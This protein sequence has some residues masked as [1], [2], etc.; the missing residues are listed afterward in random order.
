M[1]ER[2]EIQEL[3]GPGG[4]VSLGACDHRA[5]LRPPAAAEGLPPAWPP[6][7]RPWAA[8][9]EDGQVRDLAVSLALVWIPVPGNTPASPVM[10]PG[11]A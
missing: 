11:C 2:C 1:G 8:R 6:G 10:P 9:G 4:M 7:A 3:L 5:E